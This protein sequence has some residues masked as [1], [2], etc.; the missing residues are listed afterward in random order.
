[1]GEDQMAAD[2]KRRDDA[3]QVRTWSVSQFCASL[4]QANIRRAYLLY[5]NGQFLRSHEELARIQAFFELSHDFAKHEAVFFEREPAI[6]TIF[7]AFVHDTRRGLAQGG[8][9]L[10]TYDNMADLLSDGLRLSQGMTR[11]NALAGLNWGGGKGIIALPPSA[12]SVDAYQG[13]EFKA[14]RRRLFAAYGRFVASLDG[15]YYT[16]ED[17]GTDTIDMNTVLGKNR[18]TTCIATELGGSGNPSEHTA[19]GVFGAMEA[20]WLHLRGESLMGVHVAVQGAGH[21]GAPLIE[22]L[23]R[24]GAKITIGEFSPKTRKKVRKKYPD[25][26]VLEDYDGIFDVRADIFAPCAKGNVLTDKTIPRL[27]VQLVCGAANN[28]LGEPRDAELL[29]KQKVLYVPDY[30]C[31]RMGIVNCADE[32]AGHLNEDTQVA[33]E[34]VYPDTLRVLRH[35]SALNISPAE[36]ADRLADNAASELHPVIGHRGRRIRDHL[37]GTGWSESSPK[38][39][40]KPAPRKQLKFLAAAHEPGI[41]REAERDS[42]FCGDGPAIA[43]MPLSTASRPHLGMFLSPLLMDVAARS[44]QGGPRRVIGLDHGG[45]ALQ[46]AVRSSLSYDVSEITRADFLLECH[47]RHA[48]NDAAIRH[49]LAQAGIGFDAKRWLDPMS[50][51]GSDVVRVLFSQ[52]MKAGHIKQGEHRGYHCPQCVTVLDDSELVNA[53]P[54][55]RCE[56]CQSPVTQQVSQQMLLDLSGAARQL[57]DAIEKGTVT[58][59]DEESRKDVLRQ[60]SDLKP[61]CISRQ[62]WWGNELPANHEE[63]LSTWFSLAAWSLEATGWPGESEPEPIDTVF[64]DAS[65]LAH[66]IVPSQLVALAVLGH[67]AFLHVEIHGDVQVFERENEELHEEGF[68]EVRYAYRPVLRRMS[69]Q[70]GNVVEPTTIVQRFGADAL[71]LWYLLALNANGRTAVVLSESHARDARQAISGLNDA[72]SSLL[73]QGALAASKMEPQDEAVIARVRELADGALDAYPRLRF[74]HAARL[75]LDAVNAVDSYARLNEKKRSDNSGETASRIVTILSDAFSPICPFI[76]TRFEGSGKR[77]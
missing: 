61:I 34:H 28:Q 73:S 62:S 27:K 22:Y 14:E 15:I 4:D 25:A 56:R 30:L 31:N 40:R 20:A 54:D 44:R 16:A 64:A 69:P 55:R 43:A 63:V 24:A 72:L 33:S 9:R 76:L 71:R 67:P 59:S 19:W 29:Q 42:A 60:L 50:S 13:K 11:K 52:L 38:K 65:S 41:Y 6:N 53:G 26:D 5:E 49:Q 48:T 1:M 70:L 51:T 12:S 35:A 17:M 58:F 21:V 32:W 8:L 37:V 74:E 75:F 68:D 39:K 3:R 7:A 66:W 36:A 46:H 10:E 18:F 57:L 23:H 47:D 45:A 77:Q 2:D